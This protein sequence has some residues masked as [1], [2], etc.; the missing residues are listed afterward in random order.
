MDLKRKHMSVYGRDFIDKGTYTIEAMVKKGDREYP[1][2]IV[3]DVV[4]GPVPVL[5]SQ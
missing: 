5:E 3:V 4:T 2:T 1:V